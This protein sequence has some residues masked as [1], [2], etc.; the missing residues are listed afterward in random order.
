MKVVLPAPFAPSRPNA[1]PGSIAQVEARERHAIA[2]APR[3]RRASTVAPRHAPLTAVSSIV[4][5]VRPRLRD[6]AAGR[7]SRRPARAGR[8]ARRTSPCGGRRRCRS[9]A[10]RSGP[11]SIA[12]QSGPASARAPSLPSSRSSAASRSVSLMRRFAT[13]S[14]R[15][16]PSREERDHREREHRVGHLVHVDSTPRE[17]RRRACA[18]SPSLGVALDA[19]A[20]R[21]RARR[22]AAEVRLQRV[23]RHALDAHAAAR[24]RGGAERI[25]GGGRVGL[26]RVR[27]AGVAACPP[28]R[29][30]SRRAASA[31]SA[32]NARITWSVRST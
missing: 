15:V 25:G 29:A 7:G 13:F 2:E 10:P 31:A 17:R 21:A 26:D 8:R 20:H 5:V 30:A 12:S 23:G 18:P 32:P 28:R 9:R 4:E 22:A 3:E 6:A 27:A 19:A 14:M 11:G 1:S 16:G 24:D